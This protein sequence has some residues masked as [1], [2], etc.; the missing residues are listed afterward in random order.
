MEKTKRKMQGIVVAISTPNT[1]KVKVE[2]NKQH[3]VYG[4]SIKTHKNY[5]VD[6]ALGTEVKVGEVVTIVEVKPVSKNKTWRLDK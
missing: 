3:P 5:L 6:V 2:T 1:I 4:K